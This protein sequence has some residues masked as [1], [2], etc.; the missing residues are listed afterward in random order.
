MNENGT[1]RRAC[2]GTVG[3]RVAGK[4]LPILRHAR[5]ASGSVF[6]HRV[7][8]LIYKCSFLFYHGLHAPWRAFTKRYSTRPEG[9]ATR[10]R[11]HGCALCSCMIYGATLKNRGLHAPWREPFHAELWHMKADARERGLQGDGRARIGPESVYGRVRYLSAG[12][13]ASG[14]VGFSSKTHATCYQNTDQISRA[15]HFI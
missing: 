11:K 3:G 8:F 9:L 7:F 4:Y 13:T 12:T 5:P 14:R 10:L 2:P 1:F 15:Y 6:I